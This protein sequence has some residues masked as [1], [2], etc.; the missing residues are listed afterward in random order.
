MMEEAGFHDFSFTQTIF[1]PLEMIAEVEP[2]RA[3]YGE[4][5]FVAVRGRR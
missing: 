3:G 1:Q 4:G 2:V 5:S